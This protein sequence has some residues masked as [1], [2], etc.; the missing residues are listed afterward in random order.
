MTYRPVR[1]YLLVEMQKPS[2]KAGIVLPD[3]ANMEDQSRGIVKGVGPGTI[4]PQSGK[5]IPLPA[6]VGD[7]IVFT[8]FIELKTADGVKT[9]V[10]ADDVLCTIVGEDE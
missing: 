4:H 8:R 5:H 1:D 6:Q 7:M 10:H 2:A 9:I 3:G